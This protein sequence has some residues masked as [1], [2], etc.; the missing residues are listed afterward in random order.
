MA[1]SLEKYRPSDL[2]EPPPGKKTAGYE[3]K[4][5]FKYVSDSKQEPVT[6]KRDAHRVI[7]TEWSSPLMPHS[8]DGRQCQ[9]SPMVS[10][11]CV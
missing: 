7:L 2:A 5:A 4:M 10:A 1:F 9:V 6:L 3:L 11:V 8:R